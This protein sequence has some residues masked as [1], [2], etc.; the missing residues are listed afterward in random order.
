MAVSSQQEQPKGGDAW[1]HC[2]KKHSLSPSMS[3]PVET[4]R[5]CKYDVVFCF[6][7]SLNL[8]RS[9]LDSSSAASQLFAFLLIAWQDTWTWLHQRWLNLH[10]IHEADEHAGVGASGE[11]A[12]QEGLGPR[13][14]Q[15]LQGSTPHAGVTN[16]LWAA[17]RRVFPQVNS[18]RKA[19]EAYQ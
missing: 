2:R 7:T 11:F 6:I 15:L 19:H 4:F 5:I 13:Q 17:T 12:R 14:V 10:M 9:W 8:P 16:F 1:S 18:T 3:L